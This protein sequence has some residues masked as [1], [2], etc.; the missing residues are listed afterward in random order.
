MAEKTELTASDWLVEANKFR[1]RLDQRKIAKTLVRMCANPQAIE[2]VDVGEMENW[3]R[4]IVY[5]EIKHA[6]ANY[7][8]DKNTPKEPDLIIEE[9]RLDQ[10]E[11]AIRAG[12]I[13]ALEATIL[14]W[15]MLVLLMLILWRVW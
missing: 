11:E 3:I 14:R 15:I 8:K 6:I 4:G 1:E 12:R 7:E 5:E 10:R 2:T 13:N 9:F